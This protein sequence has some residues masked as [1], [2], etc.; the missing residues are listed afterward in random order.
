MQHDDAVWNLLSQNFCSFKVK[1]RTNTFCKHEYNVTG[2]CSRQACP[3]ANSRYAT[4]LEREGRC[5]MYIKTIER[6]HMPNKL[7]EKIKLPSNYTKALEI[8][9]ERMQYWPKFLVHKAKQRLTK[10]TQYLIRKRRLKLRA[11]TRLVGIN[12]KVEKRDRSREAKALRAAKLDRTIEK[13]L[14]ERLRSGTYDSIYNFPKVQYE[15]ALEE[16]AELEEEEDEEL[17]EEE[18]EEMEYE[19]EYD[20]EEDEEEEEYASSMQDMEDLGSESKNGEKFDFDD[21]SDLDDEEIAEE[22]VKK[23]LTSRSKTR[24]KGRKRKSRGVRVEVEYENE[25]TTSQQES[26]RN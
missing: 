24:A 5:V 22:E 17:Q 15:K 21:D 11:K 18:E 23:V 26:N 19:A 25:P 8:V 13:E 14:L 1:T 7:W 3:L 2:L 12:K 20:S 6:A 9:D 16:E 10:I 4:I